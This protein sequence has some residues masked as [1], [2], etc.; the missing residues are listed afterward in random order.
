MYRE[1]DW[2]LMRLL[3]FVRTHRWYTGA[4]VRGKTFLSSSCHQIT[5][6]NEAGN[7]AE[8]F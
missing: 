3:H 5:V 7:L 8:H 6:C 2:A 1:L 4:I